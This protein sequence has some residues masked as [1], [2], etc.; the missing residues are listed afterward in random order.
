MAA[1]GAPHGSESIAGIPPQKGKK[2]VKNVYA[3]L[4]HGLDNMAGDPIPVPEGCVYVTFALCGEISHSSY[5]IMKAFEEPALRDALKDPVKHIKRLTDYFGKSLHV[6]YPEAEDEASRTYYDTT[7]NPLLANTV[8]DEPTCFSKKSGLYK[9][10]DL[11]TYKALAGTVSA[12]V[13][14][15]TRPYVTSFPCDSVE[16]N[17]V[18]HLYRGSLYPTLEQMLAEYDTASKPMTFATFKKA[19]KKYKYKQSWAFSLWPGV[20]YNFVC[21][22]GAQ[23]EENIKNSATKKRRKASAEAAAKLLAKGG[24]RTRRQRRL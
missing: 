2:A 24:G 5:K 18:R 11:A 12:K 14:E 1:A 9:L 19:V 4:S 21:R 17:I 23:T 22:G 8:K 10:G 16:E 15:N 3:H 20:H 6:H 13:R 7:Y